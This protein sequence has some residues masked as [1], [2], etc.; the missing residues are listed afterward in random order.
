MAQIDP[1][2]SKCVP[3]RND[4]LGG[5]LSFER[6]GHDGDYLSRCTACGSGMKTFDD[7]SAGVEETFQTTSRPPLSATKNLG[8]CA[9]GI[10][11]DPLSHCCFRF[12][13]PSCS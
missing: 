13:R 2:Q 6:R 12:R 1:T 9:A 4:G 3:R 7:G 5:F 8:E 11:A 10:V